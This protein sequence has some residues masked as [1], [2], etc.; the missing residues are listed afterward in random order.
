MATE[1]LKSLAIAWR[2]L[3]DY[4]FSYSERTK[5]TCDRQMDTLALVLHCLKSYTIY[6]FLVAK[7]N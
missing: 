4:M 7:S 3:H 5:L 1:K 2:R 6:V